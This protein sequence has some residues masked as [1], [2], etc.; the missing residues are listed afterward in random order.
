[1]KFDKTKVYTAL[2]ADEVKIGSIGF[3]GD[4]MFGLREKVA[5]GP[6]KYSLVEIVGINDDNLSS[7]FIVQN[8]GYQTWQLFYF[9][10]EPEEKKPRPYKDTAEMLRDFKDRFDLLSHDDRLPSIWIKNKITGVCNMVVRVAD[11][12]A[13]IVSDIDVI[14]F[15]MESL[16]E[17]YTY[18]DGSIIGIIETIEIIE[19]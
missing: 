7:R 16:F 13:T 5:G 11:N 12:T 19:E 2:S 4:T 14:S 15:S 18:L 17:S 9:V 6:E 10:E 8:D 3:V 1:M